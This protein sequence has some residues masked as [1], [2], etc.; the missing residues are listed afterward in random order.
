MGQTGSCQR[1]EGKGSWIKGGEGGSQRTYVHNPDTDSSVVRT[2]GRGHGEGKRSGKR[3]GGE[4]EY[5]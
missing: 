3:A 4:W 1:V 2:K 5:L